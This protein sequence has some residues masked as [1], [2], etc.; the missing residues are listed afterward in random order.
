[1]PGRLG[2]TAGI[3]SGSLVFALVPRPEVL[4][5]GVVRVSVLSFVIDAAAGVAADADPN[6]WTLTSDMT[7]RMQLMAAPGRIRATN[8]VIRDGRRSFTSRVELTTEGGALIATGAVG[9]VRVPRKDSDPPKPLITPEIAAKLFRKAPG[10]SRPLREEA[11]IEVIDP[12]EG[13][14]QV[15]VTPDLRNPAGTLQ[16]AMVA[17]VAEVATEELLSRRFDLPVV[18]TDLDIRYLRRAENGPVRTKSR[19]LGKRPDAP[20]EVEIVDTSTGIVTTLVYAR[21]GV[22]V[23]Q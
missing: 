7:V 15:A 9:F 12:A 23:H 3:E 18:V 20:V 16:G 13:V 4:H 22:P 11:G 19:L 17:L 6:T 5:H 14:V 8:T 10:L 21:A 1:M 2:L